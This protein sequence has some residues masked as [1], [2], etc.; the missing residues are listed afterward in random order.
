MLHAIIMAGGKGARFWP[1][2]RRMRPKQLLPL[3]GPRSMLQATVDRL[4]G[5]VSSDRVQVVTGRDLVSTVAEQIP[6]LPVGAILGEPANRDTAPCIGLA[7][8]LVQSLDADATMLV[9]P[10]DHVISPPEPFHMAVHR[11]VEIVEQNPQMMVTFGVRPS[12]PAETYGYME[13]G[14]PLDGQDAD[15]AMPAYHVTMFREKPPAEVAEQFLAAGNVLWNSG[16]FIW[17]ART[18]LDALHQ[19]EPEMCQHLD[20]IAEARGSAAYEETLARE[21]CAIEG[22]SIDY[23]VME[24]YKDVALIEVAFQW[25]D[26]GNWRSLVRASEVDDDGNAVQG[27]HLGLNTCGCI[28]R[29]DEQHLIVTV[30]IEDL[31]VVHTSDATLIARKHDEDSLRK[32][33]TLIEEKGWDEFL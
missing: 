5:L 9:L 1:A 29:G 33:V 31:I 17:K 11:A 7:A 32:V 8:Q 3:T 21:F 12:F 6:Q 23:A 28:V 15:E 2:S 10:A 4:D 24:R 26:M 16:I 30:G 14:E 22:K 27:R 20:R 18:I 19:N 25:D 13:R